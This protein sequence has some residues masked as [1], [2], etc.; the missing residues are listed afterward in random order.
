MW[1][2]TSGFWLTETNG[3]LEIGYADY[4]VEMFGGGDFEKTYVLDEEN[5]KKLVTALK[6]TYSGSLEEMVEAAF[7][8]NF[9]DFEFHFFC[10]AH[11]IRFTSSSWTS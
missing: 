10:R 9:K 11:G 6:M 2:G 5:A 4:G 3:T 8:R 7:G 1:E